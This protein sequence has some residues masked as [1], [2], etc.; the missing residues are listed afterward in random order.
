MIIINNYYIFIIY[1]NIFL[2][3]IN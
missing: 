2:I 1:F 3:P